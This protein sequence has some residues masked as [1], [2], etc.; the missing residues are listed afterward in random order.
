MVSAKL[1]RFE[2][3]G[4]ETNVGKKNLEEGFE[5]GGEEMCGDTFLC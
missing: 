3:G 2:A 5:K 1:Q 4:R